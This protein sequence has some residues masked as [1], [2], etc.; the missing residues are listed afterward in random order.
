MEV[1]QSWVSD[2]VS[3]N[4]LLTR[5]VEELETEITSRLLLERRRHSEVCNSDVTADV[6]S[7]LFGEL[8]A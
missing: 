2:L 6:S 1:L 4:T 5:T 8:S 3:Q 7:K